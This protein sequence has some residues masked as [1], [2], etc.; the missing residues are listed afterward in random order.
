MYVVIMEYLA[1]LCLVV[2]VDVKKECAFG[3]MKWND[4]TIQYR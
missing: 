2:V 3:G 4:Y 1:S